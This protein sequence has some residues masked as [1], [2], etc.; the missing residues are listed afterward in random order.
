M[1]SKIVLFTSIFVTTFILLASAGL[2]YAMQVNTES[3]AGLDKGNTI[4][5][6]A[7]PTDQ[8][9]ANLQQIYAT[10]EATYQALI[11]QA[12]QEIE[13]LN[14]NVAA[15]QQQ[16]QVSPA[17]STI[18]A[19]RAAQIALSAAGNQ[20]SLLSMPGLVNYE[21]K[22]AFEVSLQD[23]QV[24]IDAV[25]GQILFNGVVPKITARQAGEIAGQYLGGMDP[26][27]ASIKEVAIN[28]TQVF[29]VTFSGD[30]DYIV[31]VDLT[32]KVIRAQIL[33]YAGGGGNTPA[34]TSNGG[35]HEHE[36]DD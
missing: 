26:K 21:G 19:D 10:R 12:N 2:A 7:T 18:T 22:T 11:A 6:A 9:A 4:T 24:Y 36:S 3:I 14:N 27:Y 25:S 30:R 23:G 29:R 33:D 8:T 20:E 35:D 16:K 28:G 5:F 1:K 32:G 31:F 34:S 15:L 17:A 13:T